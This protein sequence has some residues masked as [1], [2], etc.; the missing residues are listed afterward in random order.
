MIVGKATDSSSSYRS[1][2]GSEASPATPGPLASML[3]GHE[4][5]PPNTECPACG[6]LVTPRYTL[7]SG[8][9]ICYLCPDCGLEFNVLNH[10]PGKQAEA[11]RQQGADAHE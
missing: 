6:S 10:G 7:L 8:S 3:E 2:S 9:E 4:A 5:G 1:P 11:A